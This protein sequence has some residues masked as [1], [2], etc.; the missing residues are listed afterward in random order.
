MARVPT[1]KINADNPRGWAIINADDFDP[2]Q[3][4]AYASKPT[5][6]PSQPQKADPVAIATLGTDS[7]EQFS[8]TQLRDVIKEA[9]GKMPGPRT[10]REKLVE[11]FNELNAAGSE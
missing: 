5:P 1:I 11:Q 2:D 3:H 8:D 4:K 10:S 9:T 7:G 6:T